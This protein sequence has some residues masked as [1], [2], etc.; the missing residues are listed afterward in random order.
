MATRTER[1]S[2]GTK[3]IPADAYYG[4]QTFRAVENF[5]ISGLRMPVELVRAYTFI[6]K[7]AA[8]LEAKLHI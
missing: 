4:I 8:L 1:D 2:L 6:K 3:R 5:P 7:A